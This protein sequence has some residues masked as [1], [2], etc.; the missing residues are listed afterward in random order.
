MLKLLVLVEEVVRVSLGCEAALVG[1]LDKIFIALL[2]GESD[3]IL[4]GIELEVGALHSIGRRLPSHE[5]VLPPVTPLQDIP[6]H[7]PVV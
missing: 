1:L 5:R 7:T 2:V 3:R 6:V 4:L